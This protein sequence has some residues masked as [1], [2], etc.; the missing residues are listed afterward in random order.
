MSSLKAG[1][2]LLTLWSGL[3]LLVAA[4]VTV[5][6]LAGRNA[7]ALSMLFSDSEIQTLDVKAIAVVNAQAMLANPCIVALC[8]VVMVIIWKGLMTRA[9]WAFW[10]LAG[11]LVPLQLFGFASDAF[12]GDHNLVANVVSTGVLLMGLSL[13]AFAVF[14]DRQALPG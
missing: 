4:M 7:P 14:R 9:R 10:A 8:V 3:N 2:V 5:M 1:A 12:L 6:T 13:S 11:A